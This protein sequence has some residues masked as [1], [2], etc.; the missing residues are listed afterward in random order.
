MLPIRILRR[1]APVPAWLQSITCDV[2]EPRAVVGTL[3]VVY[4]RR[5]MYCWRPLFPRRQPLMLITIEKF[6]ELNIVSQ[7]PPG[8]R[9]GVM[10]DGAPIVPGRLISHLLRLTLGE[11]LGH[12]IEVRRP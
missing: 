6:E 3:S 4:A 2:G 8:G 12:A 11:T 9:G 7:S 1:G 5:G 10:F